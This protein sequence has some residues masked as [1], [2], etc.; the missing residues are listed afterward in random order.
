[1]KQLTLLLIV[2]FFMSIS[3]YSTTRYDVIEDFD[4]GVV[5]LISWADEDI[6]P[7]AW[8]LDSSITH[9]SSAYSLCLS[10]NTWKQQIINPVPIDSGAVFQVSARTQ[11]GSKFQG[12]GF[13]D[14][15]NTLFYSLSGTTVM[16]I[17]VWI[18]VYQGAFSNNTWND[19]MLPIADDWWS[20]FDYLPVITSIIY[21]NDLD[22]VSARSIWFDSIY[23]ISSDIPLSPDV[24]IEHSIT[25]SSRN[26]DLRRVVGV[27]FYSI[28]D[29]PGSSVHSY[30]WDFGD[31]TTSDIANPYHVFT[32]TDDR[33]WRVTLKLT[34]HYGK[35][36]YASCMI[37]VDQ[38]DGN[39]PITMNFVGDI[40]L[41]RK[42]ENSGGI[43][44][45]LGVNAIFEPTRHLL[46][47]AAD[48]TVA[49]L[50]VPLTNQGTP[51]P[52]K[53]VVYRGNPSN[54]AGLVYA[55]IDIVSLAN[56][57]TLDYGLAGLQQTQQVLD[58][59]GILHSG[60][61]ADSYE[62]YAPVFINKHG[63]NIAFLRSSDRTGQYN[64][65]QPYLQAGYNKPGFAYMTPYYIGRQ[66]EA[67]QGIA[68]L[69]I[70]EMHGGSEYSLTPGSGY[71]KS[72]PFMNDDE[73]EDYN[74]RTDVPH[75]WDIA[76]R[77]YAVDAGADLVIV[78]HPHIIQGLEIYNGKLIAHSLG[79]F[80]FDLDYPETMPSMILYAD[81]DVSGFSNYRV[82]PIYIDDY[83]PKPASGSLGLYILDY[84]AHRSTE[85]N[86]TLWVDKNNLVAHVLE[87]PDTAIT[88][89]H[90][91]D[92]H[93][94]LHPVQDVGNSTLP[95]KLPRSGSIASVDAVY[96]VNDPLVRLGKE[97]IWYGN[98]EDEGC[99]SWLIPSY[100]YDALDG[101]RSALL[102]PSAGQTQTA[103]IKR[104]IK[105]YDNTRKY[106]L[107]GW[108]KTR[109]ASACNIT[110][111][112]FNSR[113][114]P[115]PIT[116]Q[117]ITADISGTID[118]SWFSKEIT[119]PANGWFYDI[120]LTVTNALGGTVQALFDN[121][122]LIEWT[123]WSAPVDLGQIPYPN[124]FYWME[125]KTQEK[126]KSVNV[127]FTE[128]DFLLTM[129]HI[130]STR[131]NSPI[132][133]LKNYPNPFNPETMIAFELE[134]DAKLKLAVYNV[135]GQRVRS[136][137]DDNLPK[138]KHNLVW[139]GRDDRNR[140]VAS[141]IYLIRIE[142]QSH[143][144][145]R[146]IMLLK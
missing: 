14:G 36:G 106:S 18:P 6:Q 61:G 9:N 7:E 99:N 70:V 19:Y 74:Y 32:A 11:S 121:V 76:I 134:T 82:V 65:A 37:P 109:N 138:G 75:M 98:F 39:L 126:V 104:K 16:N 84:L 130:V 85:R 63:L 56:N 142:S 29:D 119:F 92:F 124:D 135:K 1:M 69:K 139:N 140:N 115:Q 21:V 128:K 120:Q 8:Y 127:V 102:Q 137:I 40:M 73:D 108:I 101:Q 45:T 31:T 28:I 144:K 46:G 54:V 100:S 62:A 41:A 95:F 59:A 77:Q 146:K 118:W 50:E 67:V 23:N 103:T 79:N 38:G 71:D 2:L 86:T 131:E 94:I 24:I 145:V 48:I 44:P 53:S 105:L 111:R 43:I 81:A 72:N 27:Q 107:H 35:R 17:E 123:E 60:S 141:G 97:T 113:T 13:N 33:P 80:V 129:P 96:P 132:V 136:L 88:L 55:G 52:T 64:N 25:T 68:D 89:Q 93:R 114:S 66:L 57:H 42:Y 5:D 34:N 58:Q 20:F 15:T 22:G 143:S 122:G 90:T 30:E 116:T 117:S 51:H 87:N 47:T 110:I 49:N 133:D 10:G 91:N 26:D 4:T 12:I 3:A 125:I 83:I 112:Y 78:H